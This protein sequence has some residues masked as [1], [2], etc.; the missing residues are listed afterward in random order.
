[1]VC[2]KVASMQQSCNISGYIL[3]VLKYVAIMEWTRKSN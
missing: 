2:N 1:M 3:I